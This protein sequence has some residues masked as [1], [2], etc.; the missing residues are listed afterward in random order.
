M[1]LCGVPPIAPRGPID[2]HFIRRTNY[3]LRRQVISQ[4]PAAL[5]ES[6]RLSLFLTLMEAGNLTSG[7]AIA[8]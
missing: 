7:P 2:H 1:V 4:A 6:S 5:Q 8:F 3:L